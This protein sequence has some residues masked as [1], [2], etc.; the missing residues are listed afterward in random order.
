VPTGLLSLLPIHAATNAARPHQ[1][2][3][4]RVIS[5]YAPTIRA[6]GSAA[7][8]IPAGNGRTLVVAVPSS[9]GAST[10]PA[11]H[12]E[13]QAIASLNHHAT[14]L[15]QESATGD[16]ILRELPRHDNLH[17]AGHAVCSLY[18]PSESALLVR[19]RPVTAREISQLSLTSGNIAYLSACETAVS[20]VT[21]IDEAIN[22]SSAC[23]LAGFRHV[24]ATLWPIRDNIAASVAKQIWQTANNPE[25][26]AISVDQA[27]DGLRRKYP[28]NP[29]IWAAYI[30][31]GS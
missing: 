15:A 30:H 28:R 3:A 9:P 1:C 24:I 10:L 2:V 31:S 7:G 4:S 11:A 8:R 22:I 17:F 16:R 26:P 25:G 29:S 20:D 12:A 27:I 6:L 13:G 18:S 19:D 5:S 23:Q 14:F 21:L